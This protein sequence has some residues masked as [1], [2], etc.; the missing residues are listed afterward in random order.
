M[1]P[2]LNINIYESFFN[3]VPVPVIVCDYSMLADIKSHLKEQT[4]TN[5]RQYLTENPGIIKKAFRDA[6]TVN[7][8]KAAFALFGVK[9]IKGVCI[10]INSLLTKGSTA[11][12]VD[13][14]IALIEEKYDYEGQ[15][16]FKAINKK[17][18]DVS[19]RVFVPEKHR[20]SFG[21]VYITFY[22]VTSWQKLIRQ[23]RSQAQLDSLTKLLNHNAISQRLEEEL[24]RAKRYG[25]SLA[26]FMIDF[27]HFKSI[28]DRFGHQRGDRVLK[29]MASLI[30]NSVR[31]VDLVGRYGGDEFLVILPST[32]TENA[33]VAAKRI[34]DVFS[35]TKIK[36]SRSEPMALSVSIGITG[37]P[38]SRIKES[39]D[40]IAYADKAMYKA[41]KAGRNCIVAI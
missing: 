8:N 12:L 7:S 33:K 2:K 15:I 23:L 16:K 13:H 22:D 1:T 17:V 28:N 25:E 39:K 32:T 3:E 10:K 19:I 38:A 18:H 21:R 14:I 37:Y 6:K 4:V 24:R 26:C 9:S 36:Y 30:K 5:V 41:K 20:G 40:L 31:A 35:A 29:Q 11:F 34:K 27:D